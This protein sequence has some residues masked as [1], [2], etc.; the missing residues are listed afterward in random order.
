[1]TLTVTPSHI[2][3]RLS[4]PTEH[5]RSRQDRPSSSTT[6]VFSSYPVPFM[7]NSSVNRLIHDFTD[8]FILSRLSRVCNDCERRIDRGTHDRRRLC[9]HELQSAP[10]LRLHLMPTSSIVRF[11]S[12]CGSII[13]TTTLSNTPSHHDRGRGGRSALGR[14]RRERPSTT[15]RTAS[16]SARLIRIDLLRV[17]ATST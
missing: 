3:R 11:I 12:P 9:F 1:M 10:P 13:N 4:I 6:V 8:V 16:T 15:G 14:N 7:S 5:H 2:D 17:N